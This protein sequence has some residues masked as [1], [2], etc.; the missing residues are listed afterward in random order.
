MLVIAA[1]YGIGFAIILTIVAV[2]RCTRWIV[3]RIRE[4]A[5][6]PPPPVVT[7]SSVSCRSKLIL[8]GLGWL[9]FVTL[10]H[11]VSLDPWEFGDVLLP[12]RQIRIR[13]HASSSHGRG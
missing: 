13:A 11:V 5:P 3:R 6:P 9:I 4:G 10:R 1:L 8:A 2:S 12:T 7:Q